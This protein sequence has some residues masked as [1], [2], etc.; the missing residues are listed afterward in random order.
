MTEQTVSDETL[1]TVMCLVE[2]NINK[3]PKTTVSYDINDLNPLTP[4]HLLLLQGAPHSLGKFDKK[5]IDV[6]EKKME[7]SSEHSHGKIS[8]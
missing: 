4:N 7:A 2:S 6:F 5:V 1:S 3:R 8:L